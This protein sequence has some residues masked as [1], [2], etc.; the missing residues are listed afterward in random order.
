MNRLSRA[1]IAVVL[2]TGVLWAG[3]G[4]EA[5]NLL[6]TLKVC[7]DASSG[8]VS[9]VASSSKCVGGAQF[10]S[11]SKSAPLLCWNASSLKPSDRTRVVS[12]APSAGCALPLSPVPVGR[13]QLL[14]ADGETGV[15]RWPLTKSCASGNLQT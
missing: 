1:G 6:P 3:G 10:W 5:G 8:V 15:L 7:V 12:V 4:A 13:A 14:C 9:R 11:A 2:L